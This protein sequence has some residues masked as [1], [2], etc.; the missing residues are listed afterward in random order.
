MVVKGIFKNPQQNTQLKFDMVRAIKEEDSRCYIRIAE[1]ASPQ[2]LEAY[3]EINK[4]IIPVIHGGTPGQYYLE[5]MQQAY[6]DTSATI[7]I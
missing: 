3:F 2:K 7:D 1:N 4:E 6:F 5:P